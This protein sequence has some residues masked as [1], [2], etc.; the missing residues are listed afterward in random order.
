MNTDSFLHFLHLYTVDKLI[1][2]NWDMYYYN[3]FP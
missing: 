2:R 1:L 3:V